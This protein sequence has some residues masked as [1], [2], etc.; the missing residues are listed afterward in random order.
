MILMRIPNPQRTASALFSALLLASVCLGQTTERVSVD[1]SGVQG[2]SWSSR[3]SISADGRYVAFYSVADNLVPGDTNGVGDIFVHDRQTGVTERVNVDSAGVEGNGWSDMPS[4]SA[5]GRYVA[6]QSEA[7]NLVPGDAN[8]VE[9]VFVHNRQTGVTERVSV[10]SPGAEGDFNSFWPSISGDGRHV[11]FSSWASNLVPGDSNGVEDVFVHN[12]QTGV[13]ERVSV[14]SSG[15][16]G[17]DTSRRPSIS[18]DGRYVAFS[19][20][21]R[22]FVPGDSNGVEDVF[23]HNRQTGVTERVSVSSSGAEGDGKSYVPSISDD[24]RFVAFHSNADNLVPQDPNRYGEIFV[25]D[26]LN[27]VTGRV[28]VS[29]SGAGGTGSSGSRSSIS[30]NGRYV[31]F[32]S[33]GGNL[34]PGDMN[35]ENDVFVHDLLDGVTERISVSS[36]SVEGNSDSW[37]PSISADGRYVAFTSEASNLVPGDSNGPSDVFV[38][39]RWDGKGQN[40]IYLTGPA[41]APVGS[42]IDFTWQTTRGDSQYWLLYSKN[43]NG[44]RID[45]HKFDL[46][47]PGALLVRGVNSTNGLGSHT[48]SPFPPRAAGHTIYFEVAARDAKGVVYDSNVVGV[49]FQ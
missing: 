15:S 17:N 2:N 37:V 6:F 3:A 18:S 9:D 40:S 1:S 31:A 19:S 47:Y 48:S 27:E 21:A 13:T 30:E 23:V 14:S 16:G 33:P 29:S 32:S 24:G 12:R 35:N 42:P 44:T 8:G 10:S 25:H 20:L 5:D 36:L 28:S 7:S 43:I 41:T 22:N 4:I 39:D 11:A 46:G 49:T 34:V 26:R 45:G 38:H